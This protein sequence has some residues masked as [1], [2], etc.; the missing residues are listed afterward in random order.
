MIVALDFD[1]VLCNRPG[2]PRVLEFMGCEPTKGA[3]EAVWWLHKRHKVYILTGRPSEDWND[4]RKWLKKWR[5]PKLEVTNVKK[6]GTHLQIDDRVI[7]F[8]N[9]LDIVKYLG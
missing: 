5:F 7:R 3:V 1:G 4:I 2:F 8:T 9:W 6:V